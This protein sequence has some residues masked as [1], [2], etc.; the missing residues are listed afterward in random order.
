MTALAAT[1]KTT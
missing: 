1:K